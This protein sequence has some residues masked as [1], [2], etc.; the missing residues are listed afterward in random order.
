[1]L[2][3][4]TP[5]YVALGAAMAQRFEDR[6]VAQVCR[7]RA[8][9][10]SAGGAEP[11]RRG[12]RA[13]IARAKGYGLDREQPLM[14]FIELALDWGCGFADDPQWPWAADCLRAEQDQLQRGRRLLRAA[15]ERSA[16]RQQDHLRLAAYSRRLSA[17]APGGGH[18]PGMALAMALL[19]SLAAHPLQACEHPARLLDPAHAAMQRLGLADA[20]A[21]AAM[22]L[23]ML[24]H[25]HRCCDD[26][27]QGWI[28]A[29]LAD[30]P[31]AAPSPGIDRLLGELTQRLEQ[32]GAVAPPAAA[33]PR[34][35]PDGI[36]LRPVGLGSPLDMRPPGVGPL[37]AAGTG[38]AA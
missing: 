32:A 5:Q 23:L 38:S 15:R 12:V 9:D 11:W 1:M 28:A 13:A 29:H 21:L 6:A 7:A 19:R 10:T 35:L 27:L 22:L 36:L 8:V 34:Q 25:G 37:G 4:S 26:P 20:R 33:P 14:G 3:I 17:A 2:Q 24:A 16:A 18:R 31:Q 30:S